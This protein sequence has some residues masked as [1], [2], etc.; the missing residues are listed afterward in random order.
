MREADIQRAQDH[1]LRRALS[2]LTDA[3]QALRAES[4]RL[5]GGLQ[6]ATLPLR[7]RRLE[8]SQPQ[9]QHAVS[10]EPARPSPW[11]GPLV[12]ALSLLASAALLDVHLLAAAAVAVL[13]AIVL[14]VRWWM[15]LLA[16][17]GLA[18]AMGIDSQVSE[19]AVADEIGGLIVVFVLLA[20]G[21]LLNE[22]W[23]RLRS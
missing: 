10:R 3:A 11:R 13:G 7:E 5:A 18:V 12:A 14:Q 8:P 15:P 2:V 6:S 20:V 21:L 19:G 22:T 17:T 16:A 1:D 9:E 4:D 23:E